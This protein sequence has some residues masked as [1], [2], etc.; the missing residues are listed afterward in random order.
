MK[1]FAP[2]STPDALP[3]FSSNL[4][5]SRSARRSCRQSL[6]IV[7]SWI[8]CLPFIVQSRLHS[9]FPSSDSIDRISVPLSDPQHIVC[10]RYRVSYFLSEL[11]SCLYSFDLNVGLFYPAIPTPFS[12]N[13]GPKKCHRISAVG[14]LS[15][16]L[17]C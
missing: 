16:Y 4:V 17:L 12:P 1:Q 3:I 13:K 10:S 8:F 11:V 5:E 7:I 2:A 6:L 9:I 15:H 14:F